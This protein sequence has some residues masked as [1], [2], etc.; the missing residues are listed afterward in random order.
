MGVIIGNR[1]MLQ[2][3]IQ[4]A[5]QIIGDKLGYF[6]IVIIFKEPRQGTDSRNGNE[7]QGSYR[8]Q[9]EPLLGGE[10]RIHP[11]KNSRQRV[12]TYDVI[13]NDLERPR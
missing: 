3:M 12:V 9:L 13:D 4:L 5:S 8:S 11:C 6:F 10:K 7:T 1:Q 2:V